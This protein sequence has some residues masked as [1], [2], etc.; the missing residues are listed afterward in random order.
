MKVRKSHKERKKKEISYIPC[1]ALAT[2]LL[3]IFVEEGVVQDKLGV[4]DLSQDCMSLERVR[5]QSAEFLFYNRTGFYIIIK[6]CIRHSFRVNDT[7]CKY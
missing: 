7:E 4:A 2:N 5:R 1:C 6:R 3:Y